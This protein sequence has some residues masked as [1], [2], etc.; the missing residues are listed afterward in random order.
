MNPSFSKTVYRDPVDGC[1]GFFA[2]ACANNGFLC[3]CHVTNDP[4]HSLTPISEVSSHF[5]ETEQN[6]SGRGAGSRQGVGS[7]L[8][9]KSA[10]KTLPLGTL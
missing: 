3:S 4:L 5:I 9:T 2:F 6:H 1:G 7:G 8:W 10:A